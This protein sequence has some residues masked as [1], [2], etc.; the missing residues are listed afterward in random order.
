MY[1]VEGLRFACRMRLAVHFVP[2]IHA[3]CRSEGFGAVY[4]H[5][6]DAGRPLYANL[7]FQPTN[8]M[9]LQLG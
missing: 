4:L 8:E 7:G 3:D 9:T 5:A 6:S 2:T 1:S